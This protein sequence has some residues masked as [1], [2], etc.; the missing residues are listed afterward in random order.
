MKMPKGFSLQTKKD[1]NSII[2]HLFK[3]KEKMPFAGTNFTGGAKLEDIFNWANGKIN[4][5]SL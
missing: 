5:L 3:G 4:E 1:G 2:A